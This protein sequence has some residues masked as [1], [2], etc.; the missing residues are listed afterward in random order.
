[1]ARPLCAEVSRENA[2]PLAATAS[3]VE[4]WLLIEYRGV[5]APQPVDASGLP[6]EVKAH[7][8]REV[9]RVPRTKLLFIRR[10][11]RRGAPGL[12][13]YAAKTPERKGAVFEFQLEAH[14]EL[15]ELDLAAALTGRNGRRLDH[16]LLVVCTHGKR[17]RCCARY[18]RPLYEGLR[19]QLDEN[20]VWQSTHV[21]GDR[22]A[23][24]VVCLPDGLYFG[25]VDRAALTDVL[26]EYLSGRIHLP[27]YRGRCCYAFA[28][29]AA[30]SALRDAFR[31]VAIDELV[32]LEAR[33]EPSERWHVR[34]QG[35][36]EAYA[37]ELVAERG[38]LTYLTCSAEALRRP[39]RYA[40]TSVAPV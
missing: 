37:V 29:Q 40:V 1:V 13:V 28:V 12:L 9:R 24:N 38:D 7:L 17:D 30:E 2:E 8:S 27:H 6:K 5:W 23:G 14:E 20:W 19:E 18:G 22:F 39:R 36:G 25:R 32:L 31:L 26:D 3:R 11:E 35:G 21:G 34:F 15:L 4:N 10:T 16:P 33:H